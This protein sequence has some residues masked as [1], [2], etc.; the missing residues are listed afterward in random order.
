MT[1][2]G[3]KLILNPQ[4]SILSLQQ[5]STKADCQLFPRVSHLE[6][7]ISLAS[8]QVPVLDKVFKVK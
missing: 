3:N 6:I 4:I 1:S 8:A 5:I 2:G 7:C